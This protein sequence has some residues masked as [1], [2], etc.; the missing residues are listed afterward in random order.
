[1][2]NVDR[3]LREVALGMGTFLGFLA[4]RALG[5]DPAPPLF[6]VPVAQLTAQAAESRRDLVLTPEAPIFPNSGDVPGTYT[7]VGYGETLS[8]I[9]Q[10]LGVS[11]AALAQANGISNPNLVYAGT[12]LIIPG[13]SSNTQTSPGLSNDYVIKPGDTLS[14]IAAANG[15]TVGAIMAENSLQS[16]DI[17]V[18][19][20]SLDIP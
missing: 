1:M 15:T 8:G 3:G 2:S 10:R 14:G 18:A 16:A 13:R 5:G 4:F 12:N 19:G 11:Q 9:A 7:T 20:E 17:I 6:P